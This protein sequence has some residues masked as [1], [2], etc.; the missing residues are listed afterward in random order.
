VLVGLAAIVVLTVA[1]I[2]AL[3][4]L[5]ETSRVQ[6]LI[7]S[8][9]SQALGR[10]VKF[11]SLSVTVLPY[12]AA[13]L[14]TLEIS[15]D[16]AFGSGAFLTLDAADF[17]LKLGALLRGR[18]EFATLVL[19]EPRIALIQGADGRWN[20]ASLGTARETA[21]AP[22]APARG[23]GATAAP[24]ALVS[25]IVVDK[26]LVTYEART[27]D[28]GRRARHRLE[29]VDLT[30]AAT[31]GAMSLA[32]AA[33]V[34]PGDVAV[35]I[36]DGT[37]GLSGARSLAEAS[38]RARLAI[39][40]KDVRPAV[41]SVWGA[42]P[43]IAGALSGRLTVSGTVARP[44]A[45]GEVELQGPTVT[46]T[47]PD[48]PEPR[49]RTL[50]LSSLKASVTWDDGRLV[51]QPLT[52]GLGRGTVAT[53]LTATATPPMTTELSDLVLK[54]IPLERVLV[55]FLCQGYAVSGA[56]DLTG[57]F[58]LA[59]GDPLRT[60]AGAGQL[61]VGPGQIVGA[62]ALTLLSGIVRLGTGV[63]SVLALDVPRLATS[64]PLEFE[65]I[66]GT[67][68]VRNG[69]VTTRDLL[70]TSRAMKVRV[71]GDYALATARVS[72]D[73]VVDD[74]RRQLQAKVTGPAAA[75]AIRV[76]PAAILRQ[77]DAERAERDLKDLLKKFR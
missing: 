16:P 75:P 55:D 42:E 14:H 57:G 62:S 64:S 38:I 15:D 54:G 34:M 53:K 21:A 12:P 56:L 28:G 67:Y 7:A 1:A 46:R 37:L 9:A 60:L 6:S 31:P 65:S 4:R 44:R 77:L 70:Y 61:R 35:R 10:P 40:S 22:R 41:A 13:R 27:A 23:G 32:G 45:A 76:A 18:V 71:A 3:P 5:V 29:S 20:F 25:R 49:R 72:L 36:S 66:V 68:Q 19:K 73:V 51:L 43:A 59:A 33:R 2:V 48:C 8:S 63:T 39:E 26:G 74:G 17:R 47:S 24:S 58:T 50:S 69:I 52:T 30:L 11:Q